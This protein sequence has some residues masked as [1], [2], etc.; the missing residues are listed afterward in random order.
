MADK[1]DE[2]DTDEDEGG[3][4][5]EDYAEP[6]YWVSTKVGAATHMR[7]GRHYKVHVS[8]PGC[9]EKLGCSEKKDDMIPV[10][11]ETSEGGA[12]CKRCAKLWPRHASEC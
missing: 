5:L 8:R 10:G 1:T 2:E 11:R 4:G 6:L 12:L 9:P 3:D 7:G